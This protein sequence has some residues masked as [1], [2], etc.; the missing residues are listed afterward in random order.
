MLR[1]T[2]LTRKVVAS[3]LVSSVVMSISV[4]AVVVGLTAYQATETAVTAIY[5]QVTDK[6]G[7]VMVAAHRCDWRGYPENSIPAIES[8]IAIGVDIIE[9]DIQKTRDG[10]LVL[11]HDTTV[12]RMTNGSGLISNMTLAEVKSL[13]LRDNQGGGGA[14]LT[15]ERIPTLEDAFKVSRDKVLINLDKGGN[16]RDQ[17]YELAKKTGVVRQ[18]IFKSS[19]ANSEVES[20]LESKK[21]RPLYAALI[22]DN[23]LSDLDNLI[24]GTRPD[25]YEVVFDSE[26]DECVQPK[27]MT[28]MKKAGRVWV[29][30]LWDSLCAGHTDNVSLSNVSNGWDWHIDNLGFDIIQT[31][32]SRELINHLGLLSHDSLPREWNSMD[33]G[34]P[35]AE[36][37]VEYDKNTG[38]F[39]LAGSGDDIWG[40]SDEFHFMYQQVQGDC[41]IAI[42]VNS[43]LKTHSNAKTGLMIRESLDPDSAFVDLVI[44]PGGGV[45]FQQRA[46]DG[47]PATTLASATSGAFLKL[48]RS[49][50]T[51]RAF[52][53][54]DGANWTQIGSSINHK[55]GRSVY[56]GVPACSHCDGALT[57]AKIQNVSIKKR[58]ASAT[59]FLQWLASY[60]GS[61]DAY[62]L[63]YYA[64][65]TAGADEIVEWTT[66]SGSSNYEKRIVPKSE[67]SS[68]ASGHA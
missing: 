31:D 34:S 7:R 4:Y 17:I 57:E 10:V 52:V 49:E 11:Q 32:R 23:N 22:D 9:I 38:V 62:S 35:H 18:I 19:A 24:K 47:T 51:F 13:F 6:D 48:I 66:Y 60:A 5:D 55:M 2:S 25:V 61:E 50:N 40:H 37:F 59:G 26:S 16:Y 33:I 8:S 41:G 63:E 15:N 20:W 21:P 67:T 45:R 28:K 12:D 54:E 44:Y 42:K 27:A 36:G 68:S 43:L 56:I 39:S 30:T 64:E 3:V 46:E 14:P 53:S 65:R 29:N 58:L 1:I